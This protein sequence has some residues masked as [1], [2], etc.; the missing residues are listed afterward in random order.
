VHPDARLSM[1]Q[2]GGSVILKLSTGEGWR[3][4]IG[5]GV[6]SI[7]ESVYFGSG[8][9]RRCEQLVVTGEWTGEPVEYAWLFEQLA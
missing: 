8:A 5:A 6:L 7:E 3:F 9:P 1:A 4:R 2:G